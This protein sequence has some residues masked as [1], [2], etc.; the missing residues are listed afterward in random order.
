M[1]QHPMNV[2]FRA[3]ASIEIGTGHVIRCATLAQSLRAQGVSVT[4]ACRE[5][6]GNLNDWLLAQSFQ[7]I[8]WQAD[9]PEMIPP[10]LAENLEQSGYDWLVVDH[11]GLDAQWENQLCPFVKQ[12][13]AIDDLANRPHE[14]DVLLDQNYFARPETRYDGLV[15]DHCRQLLGPHYALLRNEFKAAREKV[16]QSGHRAQGRLKKIQ[17]FFGGSDPTGETLSVVD[18]VKKLE[19]PGLA[20]DVIVGDSNPKRDDVRRLC[21]SSPDIAFYCQTNRMAGL[22]AE[23]DLAVS[24]GGTATWERLCLGLPAIVITVAENQEEISREVAAVGAHVYLG[25]SGEV[26]AERL[27]E[28]LVHF[29]ENPERLSE[30][31][32]AAMQLVDGGGVDRVTG[33]MGAKAMINPSGQLF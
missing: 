6:P 21:E 20:M 16:L 17:V 18:V 2:L 14:C 25:R 32:R 27:R 4:F 31:S 1:L 11:Y 23:A 26:S 24:A 33:V 10:T 3:D 15:P 9:S 5:L 13:L 29:V 22:M 8:R 28:Q 7:V 12:I 19:I 30:L